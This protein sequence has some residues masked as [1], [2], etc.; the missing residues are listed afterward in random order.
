MYTDKIQ[1]VGAYISPSI[2]GTE[3][4][5]CIRTTIW[6]LNWFS[7]DVVQK[8]MEKHPTGTV[9]NGLFCID[10]CNSKDKLSCS[11]FAPGWERMHWDMF[12]WNPFWE[13]SSRTNKEIKS[14]TTDT[15]SQ[16]LLISLL[17]GSNIFWESPSFSFSL[18]TGR[19]RH[20]WGSSAACSMNTQPPSLTTV[21]I[22]VELSRGDRNDATCF[23]RS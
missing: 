20:E 9:Y 22:H 15:L 14:T 23:V 16:S 18:V 6:R 8:L 3:T 5:F 21:L 19:W 4:P 10:F 12:F 2:N 17:C 13:C 7:N 11:N 1:T